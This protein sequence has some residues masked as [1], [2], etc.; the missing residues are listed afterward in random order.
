MPLSAYLRLF[1]CCHSAQQDWDL[2]LLWLIIGSAKLRLFVRA[3]II[4]WHA[5]FI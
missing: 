1:L 5:Q 2:G 4:Q 3:R